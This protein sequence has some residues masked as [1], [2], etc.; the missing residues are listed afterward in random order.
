[1]LLYNILTHKYSQLAI[2]PISEAEARKSECAGTLDAR[3]MRK[4]IYTSGN[5]LREHIKILQDGKFFGRFYTASPV[6]MTSS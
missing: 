2:I 6:V 4:Q 3:E 1:M 5:F